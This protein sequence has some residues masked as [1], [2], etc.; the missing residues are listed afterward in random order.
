[1]CVFTFILS[2][3]ERTEHR[4]GSKVADLTE[5]ILLIVAGLDNIEHSGFDALSNLGCHLSHT[6][7][8]EQKNQCSCFFL[9]CSQLAPFH[10][11]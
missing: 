7:F 6:N 5:H 9:Q 1:M 8:M 4:R 3:C 2:Q 10:L 11:T